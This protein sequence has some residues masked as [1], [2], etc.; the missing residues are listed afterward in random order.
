MQRTNTC[1]RAACHLSIAT[2]CNGN[3]CC[4]PWS[5]SCVIK[6]SVHS[7][8]L[9]QHCGLSMLSYSLASQTSHIKQS[10]WL[11][12]RLP[13]MTAAQYTGI[14]VNLSRVVIWIN[15]DTK[16]HSQARGQ[17]RRGVGQRGPRDKAATLLSCAAS[18][19]TSFVAVII[20]IIITSGSPARISWW[21][22]RLKHACRGKEQL[23]S[24]SHTGRCS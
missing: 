21:R 10:C 6:L 2:F 15:F 19:S 11:Q 12:L 7:S 4:Q 1:N 17:G 20:A 22:R 13:M 16:T 3:Q 9:L 23:G 18:I 8:Q 14:S 24:G 5:D